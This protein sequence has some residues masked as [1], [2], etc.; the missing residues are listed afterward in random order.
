M[1]PLAVGF[2]QRVQLSWLEWAAQLA[3]SGIPAAQ[4][5]EELQVR[6][7]P[8]VSVG[9]HDH[10]SNRGKVVGILMKTWLTP[11]DHL[12]ALHRDALELFTITP[13][14]QHIALHWGMAMA[15]YPYFGTVVEAAGRL[16][17]L[18]GTVNLA[19]VARRVQEIYGQRESIERGTQRAF[20]TLH[21][22]G[23]ITKTSQHS[24]YGATPRRQLANPRFVLWL[25]EAALIT[26]DAQSIPWRAAWQQPALFPFSLV[27]AEP[28]KDSRLELVRQGL[29]NDVIVRR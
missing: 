27:A 26:K 5:R 12:A 11:P 18:Q 21:D 13:K 1:T 19:Q 6:L 20:Y 22:W 17:A 15:V 16:L 25:I 2:T 3:T 28:G 7:R 29:D 8:I 24:V 9:G 23:V 10:R 14:E 4:A